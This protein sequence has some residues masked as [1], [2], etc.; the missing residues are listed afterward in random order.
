MFR[1]YKGINTGKLDELKLLDPIII[2]HACERDSCSQHEHFSSTTAHR[3]ERCL[4][5]RENLV[6]LGCRNRF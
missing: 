3:I 6:N 1:W 5:D 2:D 4:I